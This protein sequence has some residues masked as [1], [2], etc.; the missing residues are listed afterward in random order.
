MDLSRFA[1]AVNDFF[2]QQM[3]I[4]GIGNTE[5]TRGNVEKLM[6]RVPYEV[7]KNSKWFGKLQ[8]EPEYPSEVTTDFDVNEYADKLANLTE[9]GQLSWVNYASSIMEKTKTPK[10]KEENK[11]DQA[12]KENLENAVAPKPEAPSSEEP[13][14][15]PAV[16]PEG[17]AGTEIPTADKAAAEDQEL[18]SLVKS[19]LLD[20]YHYRSLMRGKSLKQSMDKI[21][22]L[23]QNMLEF[24]ADILDDASYPVNKGDPDQYLKFLGKLITMSNRNM[25]RIIPLWNEHFKN[26]VAVNEADEPESPQAKTEEQ[27]E[28]EEQELE[29]TEE[30]EPEKT[31]ENLVKPEELPPNEDETELLDQYPYQEA[32]LQIVELSKTGDYQA[33]SEYIKK[34]A[35]VLDDGDELKFKLLA[36]AE[37]ADE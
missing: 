33:V 12:A 9:S 22:D 20:A 35:D 11:Q 37:E 21:F 13:V 1:N 27:E 3:I 31:E 7:Y 25:V 36:I 34:L 26:L 16:E 23:M 30:P 4:V 15:E 19:G 32:M 10:A 8:Q 14:V 5:V 29:K 2:N 17:E 24:S 18:Y 6:S 28:Q